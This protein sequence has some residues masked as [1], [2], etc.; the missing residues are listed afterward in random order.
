MHHYMCVYTYMRAPLEHP[1]AQTTGGR[2]RKV[3]LTPPPS[4]HPGVQNLTIPPCP[5]PR[6][7]EPNPPPPLLIRTCYTTKHPHQL[8]TDRH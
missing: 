3:N 4:H 5:P 8:L 7:P 6:G 1:N 2:G